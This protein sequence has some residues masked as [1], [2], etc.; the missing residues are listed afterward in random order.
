MTAVSSLLVAL[1]LGVPFLPQTPALCGGASVAMVFRYWG[2][3]HADVQQFAPLVD[4]RAGGI[5][6]D[7]LVEAVRR[8]NWDATPLVGSIDILRAHVEA[9]EPLVLLI[10]DRPGR[11][12]YVVA[13]GVD[14]ETVAVHDPTW[15]PN[16]QYTIADLTRRWS[17]A[18]YWALLIRPEAATPA[19]AAAAV[20]PPE[21]SPNIPPPSAEALTPCGQ[22][23]NHA[24]ET[25]EREGFERA[26]EILTDVVETCPQSAAAH[27]ELAAVHFS[28]QR[29][30]EAQALAEKAVQ[31]DPSSTY[32]WDVLASSRF[33]Q[34]DM[35]GAL[36][37]WNHAG[38]PQVDS[39][40]IDGL[41]RTR[42]SLVAE[43]AG[44]TPN[45]T[46]SAKGFRLAE[47][48]LRELPGQSATRVGYKPE[49][50]GF[51]T[52][53]VAVAERAS[54]PQGSIAWITSG[55][56]AGAAR[57][58]TARVPGPTGM[59]EVWSG[60]WRWWSGRPRVALELAAPRFGGLP[61]ISRVAASWERQTYA[62]GAREERLHGSFATSD[63]LTPET[64]YEI[65]AGMD[66][67][68]HS[69]RTISVGGL[70]DRRLLDDRL[71]LETSGR[72][73]VPLSSHA[74]FASGALRAA[75]RSSTNDTGFV[76][77]F[78]AGFDIASAQ[79]PLALW[80]GAGDGL[81]RPA[82]L[83]AHPLVVDGAVAGPVFGRE[84][85]H[86]TTESRRW[87]AQSPLIKLA[88][89]GFV[90]VATATR[91]FDAGARSTHID[92]GA[93]L[94]VRLPAG[95]GVLRADF[96]HGVRDGRNRFSVGVIADRF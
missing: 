86:V 11:Y 85:W 18:R 80:P 50:D 17:A 95:G 35:D 94:R 20:T 47:R 67:W 29:V 74:R 96:A 71:A 54:G 76:Q 4:R 43:V 1:T 49:A 22:L 40:V 81:A 25:I 75:F 34:N 8:R 57:E 46:L 12:H 13:V 68:D 32:A 14:G 19:V 77:T 28:Q 44:L 58:V 60:S 27:A 38:K 87:L 26:N 33:L 30:I 6:D 73:F 52:V 53:H 7:V 70:I 48:R 23:L 63:W 56:R 61:G 39:V 21:A 51:A 55:V 45:T 10:E 42:Y 2:D 84:V 62:G 9:R 36:R 90:D 89:A 69:R 83:R 79:A 15:G 16:R 5:A 93:G 3:R 82:L 41:A 66:S 31:L 24:L 92:V 91:G 72:L 78:D 37:A 64:R 88:M 65:E 59:G